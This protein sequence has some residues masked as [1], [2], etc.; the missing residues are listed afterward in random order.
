MSG[1]V[2]EAEKSRNWQNLQVI[3]HVRANRLTPVKHESQQRDN[4]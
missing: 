3:G 1:N 2:V 4:V